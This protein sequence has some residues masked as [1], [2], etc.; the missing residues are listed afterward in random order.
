[1][2]IL[3]ATTRFPWPNTKGDQQRAFT[4]ITYLAAR[5]ELTV[6]TTGSPPST[7]ALAVLSDHATVRVVDVGAPVRARDLLRSVPRSVPGQVAWMMPR[8]AW[9]EVLRLA[10][11][12]DVVLAM[13]SRAVRGPIGPPLVLDHVDALSLNMRRR[14]RGPESLL[15]RAAAATESRLLLRW[16]RRL[17]DWTA[18]QIVTAEEDRRALPGSAPI[19][20]LPVAI[21]RD[22]FVEAPGH[23][24]DIDVIFTGNMRYP[25]NRAAARRFA[26]EIVPALRR[27]HA[28]LKA[29]IV[30]RAAD[31]LGLRSVS[32][33]S[34]VASVFEYLERSKVAVVPLEGGTGSPYKVLEAASCGA[35]LVSTPWAVERFGMQAPTART[36]AEFAAEVDRLL[37]DPDLR[38]SRAGGVTHP[39]VASGNRRAESRS[40]PRLRVRTTRPRPPLHGR[41]W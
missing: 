26:E 23:E 27:R 22:P 28:D 2:R 9:H 25:P 18:H 35:A 40:T 17:A 4:W 5:H 36:S 8:T 10:P 34:D 38:R 3:V 19:T 33:A 14:A 11:S 29:W 30:G 15:I 39:R 41:P 21:D 31:S 13:T 24:R 37:A 1:L 7:N 20:V 32:V 16:E 12:H 6:V